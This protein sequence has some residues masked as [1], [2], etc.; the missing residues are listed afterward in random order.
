M[1]KYGA[2]LGMTCALKFEDIVTVASFCS[3]RS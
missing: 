1:E 2:L 3:H